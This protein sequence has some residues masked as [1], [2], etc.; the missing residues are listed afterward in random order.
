MTANDQTSRSLDELAAAVQSGGAELEQ[1]L[2]AVLE[3]ELLAPSPSDPSV[4]GFSGAWADIDGV[5]HLVLGTTVE[6]LQSLGDRAAYAL[7][8]SG[9]RALGGLGEGAGLLLHTEHGVFAIGPELVEDLR[10]GS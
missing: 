4:D 7:T 1:L 2:A 10:A 5:P 8:L 6:T 9:R 3:A